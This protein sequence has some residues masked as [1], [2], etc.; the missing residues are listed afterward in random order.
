N[1][2]LLHDIGKIGIPDNIL[3][4]PEKL[5]DEEFGIMKSHA[6]RGYD[7]LK[8]ISIEPDLAIGAGYHH[9][10]IDGTG[11]PNGLSGEDIPEFAQIIAVADTYD[12][13]HSTRV[14]RKGLSVHKIAEEMKR[15]SGTQLN[16]KAV[17]ALLELIDEGVLNDSDL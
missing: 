12:A 7:I 16:E 11:Y 13:M 10:K 6:Q 5:T 1:I 3:N 9:E 15:V 14:Y 4:K 17:Q 8:E 2:A